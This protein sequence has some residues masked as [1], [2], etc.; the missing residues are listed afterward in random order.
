MAKESNRLQSLL[1]RLEQ[2]SEQNDSI[3][4]EIRALKK[5]IEAEAKIEENL[6]D[7]DSPSA[8][9]SKNEPTPEPVKKEE[10][11][12]KPKPDPI[13]PEEP[14]DDY[15]LPPLS[16]LKSGYFSGPHKKKNPPPGTSRTKEGGLPPIA[17]GETTKEKHIQWERL[18]GENIISKIGMLITVIGLS[19][20]IKYA[21]EHELITP[22]TRIVLGYLVGTS[23][24]GLALK[25]K[26]K[27]HDFSAVLL[28]GALA[29]IYFVTYAA[30]SFYAFLPQLVAFVLMFLFTGFAVIAA[31][32]YNRQIIAHLGLTGA[33][34]IPF[35]I[36]SDTDS[37]FVL[38]SYMAVINLGILVISS[39]Q[40]WKPISLTAAAFTW[41]IFYAWMF[42]QYSADEHLFGGF[43]F[44]TTFFLLF[45]ASFISFNYDQIVSFSWADIVLLLG[46][47][48]LFYGFGLTLLYGHGTGKELQGLFTIC[49]ALLHFGTSLFFYQNKTAD[50]KVF[51]LL[52][53]LV[54]VFFTLTIPVQFDGN[55]ITLF[56]ALQAAVIFMIGRT[57]NMPIYEKISY[58]V[59]IL[60][61]F[62][63]VGDW[64]STHMAYSRITDILPLFN[65][66][67]ITSLACSAA[68]YAIGHIHHSHASLSD[69]INQLPFYRYIHIMAWS[70]ALLTIFIAFHLEIILYWTQQ[71]L[72]SMIEFSDGRQAIYNR[73]LIDF[74]NIWLT[75]YFLLFASALAFI[76]ITKFKNRNFG[77]VVLA[78]LFLGFF[79][80]L[81]DG[82]S[83][84]ANLRDYYIHQPQSDY[85]TTSVFYLLIRHISLLFVGLAA[86]ATYKVMQLDGI[87]G[88]RSI[89]VSDVLLAG[90]FLYLFNSELHHWLDLGGLDNYG[91]LASRIL[92]GA[93]SLLL[94]S[95]GIWKR[96]KHYRYMA[97]VVFGYTLFLIFLDVW[98]L[99]TLAVT[100]LLVSTG[101]LLLLISF[102]Y[103]KYKHFISD[104]PEQD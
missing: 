15:V 27:Y 85:Y 93:Y 63:L 32:H 97:F 49:N 40:K 99:G 89:M 21:I 103:H 62:S 88:Q 31:L 58:V 5:E 35:L 76:N 92:W 75:N 47:S 4:Q 25:L 38:F 46:N 13:P 61:F 96:K 22:L 72:Q 74:R 6:P 78:V 24:A 3:H 39:I 77:Y 69:Q 79:G 54:L 55:W 86:V 17:P 9:E 11:S 48:F 80:F 57:M 43:F 18:I 100:I 45:Y 101:V 44:L 90:L 68:Y 7:P 1:S 14:A 23:L 60:S 66:F 82:L 98:S 50:R 37:V 87:K 73:A 67:F 33:Y 71:Y 20:F 36:G 83:S 29:T 95:V 2:L 42:G 51:F 70:A 41:L 26:S 30:Y 102:L 94:V 16:E 19:V 34:S 104:D 84:I 56:W 65:V 64:S 8:P 53:G 81:T 10:P 52:T 28:S 12:S 59:F 91:S